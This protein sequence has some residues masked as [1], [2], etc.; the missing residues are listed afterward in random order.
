MKILS[1][2]TNFYNL[3]L[4]IVIFE[5]MFEFL[6]LLFIITLVIVVLWLIQPYKNW[7]K[8][9]DNRQYEPITIT[10]LNGKKYSLE[11][12]LQQNPIKADLSLVVPSYNEE[13]RLPIMLDETARHLKKINKKYE[14]II[15]N[16]GSKDKTTQ[17]ALN[18]AKELNI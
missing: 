16:D 1:K 6:A 12:Y 15:A 13:E 14:I 5:K 2:V 11:T 18:K 4:S 3:L 7:K 9:F 8:N 17:V 10:T